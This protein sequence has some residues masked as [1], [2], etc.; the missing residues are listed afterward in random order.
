MRLELAILAT[1]SIQLGHAKD[2]VA[3]AVS[4]RNIAPTNKLATAI[5]VAKSHLTGELAWIA[6]KATTKTTTSYQNTERKCNDK[7]D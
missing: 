4:A 3:I 7:Y 2:A 5:A 6:E 1:L